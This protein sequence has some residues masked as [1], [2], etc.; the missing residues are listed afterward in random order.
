MR[1]TLVELLFPANIVRPSARSCHVPSYFLNDP[2]A[3]QATTYRNS[4]QRI[5][6]PHCGRTKVLELIAATGETEF[7][8]PSAGA[9]LLFGRACRPRGWSYRP[10]KRFAA[11]DCHKTY[12]PARTSELADSC[13]SRPVVCTRLSRGSI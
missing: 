7:A 10:L 9:V 11:L 13:G 3:G 5:V 8:S 2:A 12:I 4:S 6:W 1:E